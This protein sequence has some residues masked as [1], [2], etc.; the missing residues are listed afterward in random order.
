MR[1]TLGQLRRVYQM[2]RHAAGLPPYIFPGPYHIT[3][4]QTREVRAE[5]ERRMRVYA[6]DDRRKR[7]EKKRKLRKK[8]EWTR[9]KIARVDKNSTPV[10][11]RLSGHHTLNHAIQ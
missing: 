7:I 8:H 11:D 1:K 5:M 4:R 6:W 10:K 9:F 3:R 2:Q